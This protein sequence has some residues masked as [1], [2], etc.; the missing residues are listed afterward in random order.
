M[1]YSLRVCNGILKPVYRVTLYGL[2]CF[3]YHL[4]LCI[5]DISLEE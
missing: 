1:V 4:N 5:Y 2:K 3:M